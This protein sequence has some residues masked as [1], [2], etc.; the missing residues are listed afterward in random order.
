M[1]GTRSLLF[2]CVESVFAKAQELALVDLE[3]MRV[4]HRFVDRF[5]QELPPHVFLERRA[6]GPN[7]AAFP[8]NRLDDALAFE[9]GVRL[10]DGIGIPPGTSHHKPKNFELQS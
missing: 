10:R 1:R 6:I 5:R 7:E 9:L 8:D 2:K 4:H 3:V